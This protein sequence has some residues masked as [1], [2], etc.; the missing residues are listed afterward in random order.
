MPFNSL[1]TWRSKL[2]DV[3]STLGTVCNIACNQSC[4]F[5][6]HVS[7]AGRPW[8]LSEVKNICIAIL[9][10]EGAMAALLP[11]HRQNNWWAKPH[12]TNSQPLKNIEEA[13]WIKLIRECNGFDGIIGLMHGNSNRYFAWNFMNLAEGEGKTGS[14]EWRQPCA[15]TT[16]SGCFA[17]IELAVTFVQA[18]RKCNGNIS[19]YPR[20]VVGLRKFLF[21]NGLMAG[22]SK[23]DYLNAILN[24]DKLMGPDRVE[25]MTMT[26]AMEPS[27][28]LLKKK[29]KEDSTK[30][31][32]LY[33][34]RQKEEKD[35][36]AAEEKKKA[37]EKAR[38]EAE[39]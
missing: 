15:V 34:L 35:A 12:S 9:H 17:W 26:D 16:S 36:K 18:A 28:A 23:K 39:A 6:V 4:G 37:K 33:K 7:P 21:E 31:I 14:I 27:A 5:H 2:L 32:M 22:A 3:F 29:V 24:K 13:A 38:Q 11:P 20:T 1:G 19:T 25:L 30:N 8:H 10:F